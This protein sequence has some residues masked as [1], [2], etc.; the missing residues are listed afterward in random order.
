M[1]ACWP[2][3]VGSRSIAAHLALRVLYGRGPPDKH[4]PEGHGAP[5][6]RCHQGACPGLPCRRPCPGRAPGLAPGRAS[7]RA[8]GGGR[9]LRASLPRPRRAVRPGRGSPAGLPGRQPCLPPSQVC[10]ALVGGAWPGLAGRRG[11]QSLGPRRSPPAPAPPR[12]A[13]PRAAPPPRCAAPVPRRLVLRRPCAASV[14]PRS[15]AA[16]GVAGWRGRGPCG[17]ALPA[18]VPCDAPVTVGGHRHEV[19]RPSFSKRDKRHLS[20]ICPLLPRV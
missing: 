18:G 15:R 6:R 17:V 10:P 8:P 19:A 3:G 13:P 1:S 14:P 12:A 7:G 5:T 2:A 11:T 16:L 9:R 4:D 20:G